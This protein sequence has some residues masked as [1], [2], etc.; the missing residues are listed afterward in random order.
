MSHIFDEIVDANG[1][2]LWLDL[3]FEHRT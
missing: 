1:E 3:V 2:P